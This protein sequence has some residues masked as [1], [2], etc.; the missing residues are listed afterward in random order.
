MDNLRQLRVAR[1][2]QTGAQHRGEPATEML[3]LIISRKFVAL[4]CPC[5]ARPEAAAAV[6]ILRPIGPVS[7]VC[8]S[9]S[10]SFSSICAIALALSGSK[11]DRL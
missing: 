10:L 3:K 2:S 7:N 9:L 1:A 8:L 5:V 11:W 6:A 4:C